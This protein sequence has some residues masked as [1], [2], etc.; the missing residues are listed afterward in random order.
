M[1]ICVHLRGNQLT[2]IGT[3]LEKLRVP[4]KS[5]GFGCD[6]QALKSWEGSSSINFK[7]LLLALLYSFDSDAIRECHRR[8]N[9]SPL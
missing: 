7:C 3:A 4:Y 6:Y 5:G 1:C 9:Q 2:G 8:G